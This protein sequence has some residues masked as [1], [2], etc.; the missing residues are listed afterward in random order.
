MVGR[1]IALAYTVGGPILVGMAVGAATG[2]AY[3][4]LLGGV[5]SYISGGDFMNGFSN[6]FMWGGISGAISGAVSA[7]GIGMLGTAFADGA[8]DSA[9]YIRRETK[10]NGG[11]VSAI[12]V[13]SSFA[14]AMG[15]SYWGSSRAAK[16]TKVSPEIRSGTYADLMS[17]EDAKRYN[18]FWDYV[19]NGLSVEDRV[20]LSNWNYKPNAELYNKYKVII[21]LD[22][23]SGIIAPWFNQPWRGIQ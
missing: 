16:R 7:K 17:S 13:M 3:G 9:I 18:Q 23:E 20:K 22:V 5:S 1:A 19:E 21:P 11:D 10:L 14:M 2:A 6:G 4:G 8:V 15:I 12:G